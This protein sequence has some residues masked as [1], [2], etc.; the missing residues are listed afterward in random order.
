MGRSTVRNA[1]G[2]LCLVCVVTLLGAVLVLCH[3]SV[4][5]KL[6]YLFVTCLHLQTFPP[7]RS[8]GFV[9]LYTVSSIVE[10]LKEITFNINVFV[11][12]NI[13]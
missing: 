5:E 7:R 11:S 10:E 8:H 4:K 6:C 1:V 12:L 9:F 3:R 2:G 13:F